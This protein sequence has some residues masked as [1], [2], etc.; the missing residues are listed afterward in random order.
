MSLFEPSSDDED[1]SV[2]EMSE[3]EIFIYKGGGAI[4]KNIDEMSK[5]KISSFGFEFGY[6]NVEFHSSVT[7]VADRAFWGMFY[8]WET[9]QGVVL[10]E[11]LQKI[12]K[13][14]FHACNK[15]AI[16]KLPSTV[17]E[18]GDYAFDICQ[19][20]KEVLLN[21]G[22][23]KIEERAFFNCRSLET[24]KLPSTVAEVGDY[25]FNICCNLREVLLNEGL[26]KIG[27][28]AF[29]GCSSLE[30]LKFPSISKRLE[31]IVQ[32]GQ[33]KVEN[34]IDEI[35]I[36]GRVERRGCDIMVFEADTRGVNWETTRN[37]IDKI[38]DL[39]TFYKLKEATT[40]FELALWRAKIKDR[41]AFGID[42]RE[43]CR[44]DV[45]GTVKDAILKC[46]Q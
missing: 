14:A 24:I 5:E 1:D 18:V 45:P 25:A 35:I 10:N 37:I 43:A 46:V 42:E 39:I 12:G 16:V 15:L 33:M 44:I 3:D 28:L 22:L 36:D 21:E 27:D 7:E 11:G 41:R 6:S 4:P 29:F 30:S 8:G 23:Q 26:Q 20:L 19:G 31:D 9:L 40:I 34:K 32:A 13:G 38:I 2:D 17:T